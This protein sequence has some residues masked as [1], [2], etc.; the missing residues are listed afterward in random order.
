MPLSLMAASPTFNQFDTRT[1]GTNGNM[2]E[3]NAAFPGTGISNLFSSDLSIGLDSITN[4]QSVI[5]AGQAPS[6]LWLG[7]SIGAETTES[8]IRA[9]EKYPSP[10]FTASIAAPPVL[11]PPSIAEKQRGAPPLAK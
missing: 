3:V 6:I 5:Q 9:W 10:T 11:N 7:D 1:F 4:F 8:F 2:I